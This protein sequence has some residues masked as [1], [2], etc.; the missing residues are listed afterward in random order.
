MSAITGIQEPVFAIILTDYFGGAGEQWAQVYRGSKVVNPQIRTIN[1]ALAQLGVVTS[2]GM[3][4]FDT[5]GLGNYR[6]QPEY[7]EKYRD[8]ADTLGV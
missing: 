7:L 8:L 3:D 2:P 6:S 4:E 1:Q 5:V